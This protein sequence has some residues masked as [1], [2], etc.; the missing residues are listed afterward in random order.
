ME[1]MV[2]KVDGQKSKIN[3]PDQSQQCNYIGSR[4]RFT[5]LGSP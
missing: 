2:Q 1:E 5:E 4:I 3:K